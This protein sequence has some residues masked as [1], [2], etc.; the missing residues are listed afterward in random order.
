MELWEFSVMNLWRDVVTQD[1]ICIVSNRS[2]GLIA[3][4]RRLGVLWRSIYYI[5]HIAVNFP[6]GI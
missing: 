1:N 2:E 6:Q 5:S 3:V 4:I